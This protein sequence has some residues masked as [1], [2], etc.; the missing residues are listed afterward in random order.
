MFFVNLYLTNVNPP[1]IMATV[2][3]LF[4]KLYLEDFVFGSNPFQAQRISAL[5]KERK[6]IMKKMST[7]ARV[8]SVIAK[9]TAIINIIGASLFALIAVLFA[10]VDASVFEEA[11]TDLTLGT[12]TFHINPETASQLTNGEHVKWQMVAVAASLVVLTIFTAYMMKIVRKALKPMAE[13]N[14]FDVAVYKNVKKLGILT[15]IGGAVGQVIQF[16]GEMFIL[17]SYDFG[18]LFLSD[19]IIG[20]EMNFEFDG[21]F[22]IVAVVLFMLAYA[23]KYGAE[24]QQQ[25]DETL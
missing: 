25:S 10:F 15:L 16:L 13:Q 3:D 23:F 2:T 6:I 21:S 22:I 8:L 4:A 7:T 14:P 11:Q 12:V 19:K 5:R 1:Y 18:D 24:L 9:I 17:R 20:W